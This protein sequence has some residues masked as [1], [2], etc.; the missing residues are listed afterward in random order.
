MSR[1][2][3]SSIHISGSGYYV[4]CINTRRILRRMRDKIDMIRTNSSSGHGVAILEEGMSSTFQLHT[5]YVGK[6]VNLFIVSYSI[7][8]QVVD[9]IVTTLKALLIGPILLTSLPHVPVSVV[10]DYNLVLTVDSC[11]KRNEV[12]S[13]TAPL[14]GI[15]S[16]LQMF[17]TSR[18]TS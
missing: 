10:I 8:Y 6:V 11:H 1:W 12:L 15:P 3:Y 13:I 18:T 14:Q 5:Y 7:K 4:E 2:V 16:C 17:P 9:I